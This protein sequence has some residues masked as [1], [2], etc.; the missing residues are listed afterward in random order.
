MDQILTVAAVAQADF[1]A[2][3]GQIGH[4]NWDRRSNILFDA[5]PEFT[6]F[7][8]VCA[9]SWAW[10]TEAVQG[11]ESIFKAWEQSSGHWRW[12]NGRCSIW[13]YGMAF[14]AKQNLWYGT[15]IFG[16]RR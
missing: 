10:E 3:V 4:Q 5:L 2:R 1:Q 13:G 15:G 11:A 7:R 6:N 12:V 9:V 16:D 14:N 8:E